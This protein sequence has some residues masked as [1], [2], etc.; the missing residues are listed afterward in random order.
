MRSIAVVG[1]TAKTGN[2]A[3]VKSGG[4][5][6]VNCIGFTTERRE[7]EHSSKSPVR[8]VRKAAAFNWELGRRRPTDRRPTAVSSS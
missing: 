6:N 8:E 1:F 2:I 4:K 3:Q 5:V 7:R